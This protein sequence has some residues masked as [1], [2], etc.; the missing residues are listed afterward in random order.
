[1]C[2]L[3]GLAFNLPVS[4]SVS[5]RGFRHRGKDNPHGWGLAFYPDE[6]AQIFKEPIEVGL[7]NLSEF[8]KD[9]SLVRGKILVAHVRQRSAGT[10][11]HRNTHP[12]S[13]ELNGRDYVFAHNGTLHSYKGT[14][15]LGRFKPVGDTDSEYAFC[16]LLNCIED[17]GIQNWQESDFSWLHGELAQINNYEDFNCLLSDGTHLFCYYD[18]QGYNGL[19]FVHR[20]VPYGTIRMED[21]DLKVD[22]DKARNPE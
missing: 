8:I 10:P 14:L 12:F 4:P 13:R 7:S 3:L 15:E 6:S 17:R 21:E 16:Y 11:A 22:L 19:C 5:F 2:E 18:K 20:K 1:M 9:Y